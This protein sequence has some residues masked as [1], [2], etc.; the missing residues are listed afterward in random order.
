MIYHH[1]APNSLLGH[2]N[3]TAAFV[4]IKQY[5]NPVSGRSVRNWTWNCPWLTLHLILFV[6]VKVSELAT[7]YLT[8]TFFLNL[9]HGI[10]LLSNHG[11][12]CS[13][14]KNSKMKSEYFTS[15]E[16]FFRVFIMRKRRIKLKNIRRIN[17]SVFSID[18]L[19]YKMFESDSRFKQFFIKT[20]CSSTLQVCYILF[21]KKVSLLREDLQKL[22]NP[23]ISSVH[24]PELFK[25]GKYQ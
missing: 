2:S 18:Y 13:E 23:L 24:L 7:L 12:N 3:L 20:S 16:A 15:C 25:I 14:S 17:Y 9:C 21:P 1:L 22:D 19:A 5:S 6:L 8:K 4:S 11:R 10:C